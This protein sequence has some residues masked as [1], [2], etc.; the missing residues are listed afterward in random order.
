MT[1]RL[2]KGNRP[3]PELPTAMRLHRDALKA[4]LDERDYRK[5]EALARELRQ[6]PG[7]R[8]EGAAIIEWARLA[9]T[10]VVGIPSYRQ[11]WWAGPAIGP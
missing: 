9:S 11:P 10:R 5:A 4:L 8:E 1:L 2:V 3:P 6:A 7:F